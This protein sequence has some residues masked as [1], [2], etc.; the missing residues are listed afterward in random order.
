MT[1]VLDCGGLS[2][3]AGQ[4]ARLRAMRDAGH[5]PPRLPCVVLTESSTADPRRD[6]DAE[7]L[8]RLC[9]VATVDEPLA[10]EAARL[11]TATRRAGSV[12][13]IDALVAAYA[14]TVPEPRILTSDPADLLSLTEHCVLP[15]IVVR[16]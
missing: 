8:V 11:R 6:Y 10:R 2:A 16:A 5:W 15:V 4:R 9:T 14:A 13:A 12:S 3:L 7:R 1:F